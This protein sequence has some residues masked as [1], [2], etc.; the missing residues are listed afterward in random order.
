[1]TAT[2]VLVRFQQPPQQVLREKNPGNYFRFRINPE[3]VI[4][5]GTRVK[6]S[7][8]KLA[9]EEVEL[10]ATHQSPE[11]REPYERLLTDASHGESMLFTREDEV[12]SAWRVVDPILGNV[13]PIHFYEPQT[14]GP[15][16]AD[17]LIAADGGWFEPSVDGSAP[18]DPA[19]NADA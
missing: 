3:V 12:E 14:W 19:L 15:R 10:F 7:G 16:E 1:V 17:Q 11:D 8:E 4:A 9:G 13:S 18:T 5:L 6:V 2:E